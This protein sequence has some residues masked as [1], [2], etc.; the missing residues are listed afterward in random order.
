MAGEKIGPHLHLFVEHGPGCV[1]RE[2]H[3]WLGIERLSK[4][5]FGSVEAETG[6]A[7]IEGLVR[8]FEELTDR[9]FDWTFD[10]NVRAFFNL[11]R[12]LAD[13]FSDG[14]SIL[15]VSSWGASRA[16]PYYSLVGSSKGALEALVRHLAVELA[17]RGIRV[18]I[19]TAGAVLTDAWKAIPDSSERIAETMRRTPTGRLVTVEEIASSA[20]FLCSGA[21]TGVIGQTFVVDGGIGIV[22]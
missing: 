4:L 6:E 14:S 16:L 11:V 13:R 7:E 2:E 19:L 20:Q 8:R 21:A 10:L 9:H 15:A 17:P 5:L 3:R 22:A 12:L 1:A 18:N